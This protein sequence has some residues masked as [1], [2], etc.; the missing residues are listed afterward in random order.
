MV[1]Q[2]CSLFE[3]CN[4]MHYIIIFVKDESNNL[5]SLVTIIHSIVDYCPLKL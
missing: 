5:M 2:L 4:L 3:K 1:H